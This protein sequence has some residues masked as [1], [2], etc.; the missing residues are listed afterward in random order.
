MR[1]ANPTRW[2]LFMIKG[3][4][5]GGNTQVGLAFESRVSLL[6]VF[7]R[8][9]GFTVKGDSVFHNGKKVAVSLGKN[10]IYQFL[11]ERGVDYKTVLSKK[12]LPDEALYVHGQHKIFIV[13]IKFQE[14]PGSVD[15]KLQT[16]DFKKQQYIK[17]FGQLDI[18]VEYIYILNEWFKK[19]EYRDVLEYISQVGCHYYFHTLPLDMLGLSSGK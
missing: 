14:T 11:G 18:E 17:L 6:S 13:E 10:K 7:S 3:G 4:V 9:Q 15:E 8:T 2:S 16:C 19:P 5:G 12:L 1:G